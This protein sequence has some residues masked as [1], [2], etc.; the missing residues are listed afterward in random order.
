MP[1]VSHAFV[2]LVSSTRLAV[3]SLLLKTRAI[4]DVNKKG[5][6]RSPLHFAVKH[7]HADVV[8][9][10]VRAGGDVHLNDDRGRTPLIR[11]VSYARADL[12]NDLL[13]SGSRV[14]AKD[15]SADQALS[16]AVRLG[17]L[18]VI[19]VLLRAGA[20]PGTRGKV[21][22]SM[23]CRVGRSSCRGRTGWVRLGF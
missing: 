11:A 5:F 17:H 22:C 13:L 18:G 2:S 19:R 4:L 1:R 23:T 9:A 6:G 7:G 14:D 21:N 3:V 8:L 16:V 10:L 15:K 20:C 12:V